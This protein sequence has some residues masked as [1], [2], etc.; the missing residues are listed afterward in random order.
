M[1]AV[2]YRMNHPV[3]PYIPRYLLQRSLRGQGASF[4]LQSRFLI[5]L[6]WK[7]LTVW[8]S[9]DEAFSPRPLA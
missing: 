4:L 2:L 9:W 6:C 8:E 7:K 3:I 5:L 1:V